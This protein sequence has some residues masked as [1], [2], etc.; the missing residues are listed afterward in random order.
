MSMGFSG[1]ETWWRSASEHWIL[2]QWRIGILF[3]GDDPGFAGTVI[4]ARVSAIRWISFIAIVKRSFLCRNRMKTIAFWFVGTVAL[5]G[6]VHL[7]S[8][9]GPSKVGP[10]DH[11]SGFS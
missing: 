8:I 11:R 3:S 1:V 10:D 6:M 4:L 2:F 7:P 9:S 5:R